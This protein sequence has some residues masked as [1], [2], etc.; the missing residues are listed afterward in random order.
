[1]VTEIQT[2]AIV[3]E[4]RSNTW[5]AHNVTITYSSSKAKRLYCCN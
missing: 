3:T 2:V 5:L 1:M 4:T